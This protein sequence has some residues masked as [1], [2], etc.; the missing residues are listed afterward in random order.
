MK[1]LQPANTSSPPAIRDD[2]IE[3]ALAMIDAI[4]RAKFTFENLVPLWKIGR[5][6]V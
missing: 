4:A 3:G 2:E 5:A 6:H 1:H